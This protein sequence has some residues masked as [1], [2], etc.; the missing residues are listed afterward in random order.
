MHSMYQGELFRAWRRYP[1]P[2]PDKQACR[3]SGGI[4]EVDS[5]NTLSKPYLI[6]LHNYDARCCI[7]IMERYRS[8]HNG[9]D[10]KSVCAKAHEGSNPSLSANAK[11]ANGVLFA[12]AEREG[13]RTRSH[14]FAVQIYVKVEIPSLRAYHPHSASF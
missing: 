13:K 10:S 7:I 12:L 6:K 1:H 3:S 2:A 4:C 9:A 14:K 8:G 11:D 5:D